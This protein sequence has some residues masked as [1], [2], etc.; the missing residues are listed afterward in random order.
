MKKIFVALLGLSFLMTTA[1]QKKHT[2]ASKENPTT[3]AKKYGITVDEL[4]R[5]NPK[6]KDGKLNIGDVLVI[7]NKSKVVTSKKTDTRPVVEKSGKIY[8]KPKQTIYG[9][10]KQ[11]RISEEEL[12]KLNPNLDNHL[13]IGDAVTLPEEKIRKYGDVITEDKSTQS[14]KAESKTQIQNNSETYT[15]QPK[16]TYYGITRKFGISQQQLFALNPGLNEKGLQPNDVL[17]VKAIPNVKA[18]K[19]ST[20]SQKE[21]AKTPVKTETNVKTK[22]YSV[23]E[24]VMHEVQ[25]GDTVFGILNKYNISYQEFVEMNDNLNEEFKVGQEVRVKKY[26]KQYVKTD[27][28]VFS[29]ALMLPFGFD[30]NDNKYRTLASDF[31]MGA[32][33]AAELNAKK[34]KKISLNVIDAENENAF[35][36]SLSQINK[37]NTD[38]IVG[39]FFKSNVVEVL[40][41]VKNER[42]PVVAPFAH[43]QDLYSYQNLVLVETGKRVYAER[44]VKEVKNAYDGQ[45]I[46]IVGDQYD[47]EVNY[48]KNQLKKDI[49]KAEIV[50]TNSLYTIEL[51]QNMMTGKTS[52]AMVILAD[53][54]QSIGADFAR[55]IVELGKQTEGM[56]AFSMFYHPDFEKD[57]DGLSKSSLVYLMDRKINV[58]GGF[59]K[60][61]LAEFKKEYCK[62][63][64]K[65]M[66]VGFD[67]VNDILSRENDGEIFNQMDKVQT[68]LATKFEY[69]R[70]KKNGAFVNTG[71]RVVR[72]VP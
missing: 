40:D 60:E 63:P 7:P 55:K 5:Q 51:E 8:L 56:K 18:Q 25:K 9:I 48:L 54:N 1:Q 27:D 26:E 43:T 38:L 29:V 28:D 14:K 58:D 20:P 69:I 49:S 34:G 53:D 35:K 42:I 67:V 33:L 13:K 44:L 45:K 3:I 22:T 2:V 17:F 11:Y 46:F 61:I 10:T 52:P 15:V 39:P 19:N 64:S 24:Y 4:L 23:D 72:L 32:K 68:Q 37:T 6:A 66:I 16:D 70:P 62:S 21:M 30:S 47:D 41:Y 36:N 31:L 59:E 71:Y 50:V 12:R 57:I 65:Y